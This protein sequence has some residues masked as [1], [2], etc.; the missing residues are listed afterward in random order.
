MLQQLYYLRTYIPLL[1]YALAT[2]TNTPR[3]DPL[4]RY[5]PQNHLQI[6]RSTTNGVANRNSTDRAHS[7][8]TTISAVTVALNWANGDYIIFYTGCLPLPDSLC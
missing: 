4:R 7:S 1:H 8:T 3:L 6:S 2:G 5:Q